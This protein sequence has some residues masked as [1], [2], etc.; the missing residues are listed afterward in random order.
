VAKSRCY[1]RV[2]LQVLRK[3]T[4]NYSATLIS[5]LI[6]I[7]TEHLAESL[8]VAVTTCSEH[9]HSGARAVLF[10]PEYGGSMLL[11]PTRLHSITYQM[12]VTF[13]I[14]A[15]RTPNRQTKKFCIEDI[16][17]SRK[18]FVWCIQFLLALQSC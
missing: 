17:R 9:P 8:S 3:I 14:T 6:E 12:A 1:P 5:V 2:C 18:S 10:Y 4:Q 15:V 7:R 16:M 13:V 11:R